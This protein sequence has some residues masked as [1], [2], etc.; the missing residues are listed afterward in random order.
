MRPKKLPI[1]MW[2]KPWRACP[3]NKLHCSNLGR[4]CP[5]NGHQRLRKPRGRNNDTGT[6]E[7]WRKDKH[8]P[9]LTVGSVVTAHTATRRFDEGNHVLSK[10]VQTDIDRGAHELAV[11]KGKQRHEHHQL[12]SHY[13][14]NPL[15]PEVQE[16]ND[17]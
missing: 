7:C 16:G 8:E 1:R 17:Q 9:R 14:P 4:R 2:R 3:K 15:L 6:Q 13:Q 5:A 10:P 12:G 11:R